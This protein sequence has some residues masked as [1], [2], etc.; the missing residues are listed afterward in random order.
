MAWWA[1]TFEPG[2]ILV[3]LTLIA[4]EGI[5]A[6][7]NAAILAA[8]VRRLPK[9][10]QRKAL[11]YGLAGAYVFRIGAVFAVVWISQNTWLKLI[12]GAYLMFLAIKHLIPGETH[13]HE[14]PKWMARIGITGFWATVIQLEVT[15]LVFA[16]DQVLVAVAMTDKIVLIIAAS[17][18]AILMLRLS[19]LYVGRLMDWF[20]AMEKLAYIAVGLVGL[21]LVTNQSLKM[22]GVD[23]EI[24]KFAAIAVTMGLLIVPLI[25]KAILERVRR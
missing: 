3:V 9:E 10:Q 4:L 12:G 24:P 20:P 8:M 17:L 1:Y 7:D 23:W 11:L 6:L 18:V 15:D 16:L 14:A 22:L 21:K 2:D 25:G 19:A 13:K 5:L